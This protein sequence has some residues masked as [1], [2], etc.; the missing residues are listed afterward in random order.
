MINYSCGL[1]LINDI[2]S[3][4]ICIINRDSNE[5]FFMNDRIT[6]IIPDI[7]RTPVWKKEWYKKY[8]ITISPTFW[9]NGEPAEI[10]QIGLVEVVTMKEEKK[11]SAKDEQEHKLKL[12][13]I[14]AQRRFASAVIDSYDM[15]FEADY[16]NDILYSFYINGDEVVQQKKVIKLSD[17]IYEQELLCHPDDRHI[18]HNTF[19]PQAITNSIKKGQKAVSVKIRRKVTT[20]G[21][22]R[23]YQTYARI[24]ETADGKAHLMIYIRDIDEDEREFAQ[25]K[26]A[27]IQA[28]TKA[29]KANNAKSEFLSKISHDIRTPMN[30]IVGMTEVALMHVDNST[31]IKY[32]LNNIMDASNHMMELVNNVLDMSKIENGYLVLQEE[33][34]NLM[35]FVQKLIGIVRPIAEKKKQYIS[36]NV[37]DIKHRKVVGDSIH[38]QQALFNILSN[39]LKYT[40][41]GGNIWFQISE[42]A[43]EIDRAIYE[44]SIKDSGIGM[45]QSLIEKMFEPFARAEDSRTSKIQGMGLGLPITKSIINLMNGTIKVESKENIGTC[46]TLEVPFKVV[47]KSQSL[48]EGAKSKNTDGQSVQIENIQ[49]TN[50]SYYEEKYNSNA[51]HNEDSTVVYNMTI[52][53]NNDSD[54]ARKSLVGRR[55]LVVD[56]NEMNMDIL[57][58]IFKESEAVIDIAVNGKEA[59]EKFEQSQ[60]GY[61]QMILMDIQMPI[62]NGYEATRK[63]RELDRQDAKSI[64]IIAMTANAFHEGIEKEKEAGMTDHISKPFNFYYLS[65]IIVKYIQNVE[66]K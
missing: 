26:D 56:D 54:E 58:E 53:R 40:Q 17:H 31:K 66:I 27:L 41:K 19:S 62:L 15:V 55:L 18:F 44:V 29:E 35:Q 1:D 42:K 52:N 9:S 30:G 3:I 20:L 8:D 37:K 14:N 16:A 25:N 50:D 57:C 24:F 4:G 43:S 28:Y 39:S 61:Y 60:N 47:V 10:I 2:T 45:P 7:R 6:E 32:C 36:V 46:F 23:W 51:Y 65:E 34:F 13:K 5:I 22:Y 64:P 48:G 11:E 33:E 63:I 12:E 49:R 21:S 59:F 38:F